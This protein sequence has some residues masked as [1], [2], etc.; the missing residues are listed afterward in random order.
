MP[1][2]YADAKIY[3]IEPKCDHDEGDVYYGSTARKRLCDRYTG[4]LASYR[5]KKNCT[6]S[7]LIFEKYGVKNCHIVLV[8]AFPCTNRDEL[9]SREKHF[10]RTLLCVNE[11]GKRSLEDI[12]EYHKEYNK[13]YQKINAD[14]IAIKTKAYRKTN[15]DKIAIRQKS[16]RETNADEIAIKKKI[17]RE[18][19]ADEITIKQKKYR[20]EHADEITIKRKACREKNAEKLLSSVN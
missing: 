9:T 7:C 11:R 15:A 18:E 6:T 10:I 4:H 8:E 2:N 1:I 3:K 13:E 16:Y 20:E 14:E 12:K 5:L 19:H 17:Y